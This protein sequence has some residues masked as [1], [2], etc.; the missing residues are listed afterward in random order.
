MLVGF[1]TYKIATLVQAMGDAFNVTVEKTS[2][3]EF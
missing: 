2:L 3:E 1:F